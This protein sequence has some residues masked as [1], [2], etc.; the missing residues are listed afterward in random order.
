[1]AQKKSSS[2]IKPTGSRQKAASKAAIPGQD[3]HKSNSQEDFRHPGQGMQ[4]R[5]VASAEEEK[6]EPGQES[7]GSDTHKHT[8]PKGER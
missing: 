3:A 1:M 5:K 7:A 6:R 2:N 4:A 8:R